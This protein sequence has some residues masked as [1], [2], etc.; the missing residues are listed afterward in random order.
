MSEMYGNTLG[1]LV[2][3]GIRLSYSKV[4]T[5]STKSFENDDQLTKF[6]FFFFF[7]VESFECSIWNY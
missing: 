2:K 4:G 1:G 5:F 3:G 7:F 6:L